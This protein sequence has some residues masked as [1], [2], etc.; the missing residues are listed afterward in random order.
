MRLWLLFA[1]ADV[2]RFDADAIP[3]DGPYGLISHA[4]RLLDNAASLDERR[5][6]DLLDRFVQ[7]VLENQ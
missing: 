7:F 3:L 1:F 6:K 2:H 4:R 5:K